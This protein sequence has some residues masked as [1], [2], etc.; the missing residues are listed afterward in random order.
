MRGRRTESG[1]RE[2]EVLATLWAA[3]RPLTPREVADTVGHGL[4]YNTV[5][6]ILT[7]LYEKGAVKRERVGRA[8]A[9]TPLL[10][11]AGLAARRMHTLLDRSG[12]YVTVVSRFVGTL[13]DEQR[14]ILARLLSTGGG[15][16]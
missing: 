2:A 12:D 5:Q 13:D 15:D 6:T 11:E 4:A 1:A 3:D 16:R 8:H 10:D 7:R 9:Y 14:R